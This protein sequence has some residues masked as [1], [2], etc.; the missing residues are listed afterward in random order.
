MLR[1]KN[2]WMRLVAF[3]FCFLVSRDVQAQET[4]Q[5]TI[6]T[7]IKAHGGE[8]NLAKTL[9]GSIAAKGTTTLPVDFVDSFSWEETF[10]LPRRYHRTIKGQHVGKDFTKDFSME[11]A[12]TDGNGWIRQNGG[13][14]K[15]Y[16]GEKQPLHRSWNAFL[17]L[18]PACLAD[19]VKLEAAGNETVG[20]REAVGVKIQAEQPQSARRCN[21]SSR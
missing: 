21:A 19:G 1:E 4:P 8:Q 18:L 3:F 5:A 10:E 7:A 11:Y 15:E 2:Q 9:T 14:A 6:Q 16:K 13:E 20:G 12:I 17:T